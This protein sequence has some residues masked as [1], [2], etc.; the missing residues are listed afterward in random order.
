MKSLQGHLLVASSQ[1]LD[2]NFLQ[3]V[4]VIVQHNEN[5]ALGLVLNRP[6]QTTIEQAWSQVSQSPCS[7]QDLLSWGGPCQSILMTLHTQAEE[8]EVEVLPG[9]YF[10]TDGEKI[11]RLVQESEEPMRFFVG[12]AGWGAGQLEAEM[13]TGSWLTAAATFAHIFETSEEQWPQ[14][15]RQIAVASLLGHPVRPEMIPLD[16]TVN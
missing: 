12:Y 10:A 8:S 11:Q 2:P 13:E 6:T 3:T 15:K 1:L 7:R 4:I 14:V 16:P 5:G 9:I